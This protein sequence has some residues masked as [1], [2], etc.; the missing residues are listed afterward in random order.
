MSTN[1]AQGM[2]IRTENN[3]F[4]FKINLKFIQKMKTMNKVINFCLKNNQNSYQKMIIKNKK[5]V[6]FSPTIKIHKFSFEKCLKL[7]Q[8]W[9]NQGFN[10][11]F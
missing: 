8:I 2:I 5:V 11:K 7:A 10:Q 9:F 1:F 3:K 4:C 6:N